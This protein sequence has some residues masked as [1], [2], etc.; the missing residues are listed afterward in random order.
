MLSEKPTT[1][2]VCP[3]ILNCFPAHWLTPSSPP[4]DE[5]LNADRA[6]RLE[7]Q[8]L[9]RQSHEESKRAEVNE[10]LLDEAQAPAF[11]RDI[12]DCR[13]LIDFFQ[14]RIGITP[15]A[16]GPV[17]RLG[18]DK[19]TNGL[20]QLSQVARTVEAPEGLVAVAKKGS[21]EDDYFMGGK[22]GKKG[23]RPVVAGATAPVQALN[24]PFGT[25][26]ALLALGIT[27]PITVAEVPQTIEALEAKK[28]YFENN[29]VRFLAPSAV[30]FS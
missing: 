9:E 15:T 23:P 21:N 28:K 10:R 14:R 20:P 17:S 12:E 5:K 13:T 3:F 1:S 11:E 16:T 29:Q 27:S 4:P 25:L 26:S 19:G 7:R 6:K 2:S 22:K 8:R 18:G 24:L 30:S